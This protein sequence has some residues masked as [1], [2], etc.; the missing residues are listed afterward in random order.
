ME[1][2]TIILIAFGVG[3]F[4]VVFALISFHEQ[5]REI[6]RIRKGLSENIKALDKVIEQLEKKNGK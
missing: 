6:E 3:L 5:N 1:Q 2:S 4:T